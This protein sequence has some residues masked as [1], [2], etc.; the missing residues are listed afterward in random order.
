MYSYCY[1][2]IVNF[3]CNQFFDLFIMLRSGTNP[4]PIF[5]WNVIN[6]FHLHD[7]NIVRKRNAIPNFDLGFAESDSNWRIVVCVHCVLHCGNSLSGS[8]VPGQY[9]RTDFSGNKFHANHLKNRSW[10][11][12][13][14]GSRSHAKRPENTE[15]NLL[16]FLGTP[17]SVSPSVSR[18][19]ARWGPTASSMP[20]LSWHGSCSGY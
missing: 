13:C 10:H 5:Y 12:G 1:L 17:A 16:I 15:K 11:E 6:W 19:Y 9:F 18:T 8:P 4:I 14:W 2:L 7:K 20:T 3:K